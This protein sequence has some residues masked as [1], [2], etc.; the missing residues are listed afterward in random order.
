VVLPGVDGVNGA[1]VV[2]GKLREALARPFHVDEVGLDVEASVG[3][4]V[5]GEHG[6]DAM[7]LLQRVDVAMYVAKER[8]LGVFVYD[9]KFDGHSLERL[10]LLGQLRQGLQSSEL[11]L[12]YQPKVSLSTGEADGVEALVR[13]LHPER[14]LILPDQF[15]PLAEHTGL[16]GPLTL[17]VL[18]MALDQVRAWTDAGFPIPVSVNLSARNL[19]D[20]HFPDQV[21]ALL[22][23]H[24]VPSW[25]LNLEVTE[26]AIMTDPIRAE[27]LLVRLQGLGATIS[28]D[29]FGV[30]YTSLAHLQRLP[31]NEIKIDRS[32]VT[33]MDSDPG[34][35]LIVQ[36]VIDIGHNLGL[37]AI[38]EGV[39][40]QQ[41]RAT[42]GDLG[43]DTAQGYHFSRPLPADDLLAWY[44]HHAAEVCLVATPVLRQPVMR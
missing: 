38:A 5:S 24:G 30:G 19:L 1:V 14:G 22:I 13:W 25:M 9:S 16:I 15:I 11:L 31:V 40:S 4:V 10:K 27:R 35:A 32:F 33:R 6:E 23:K 44:V 41:V 39:E 12:Y 36:S 17:S 8:S 26:S 20:E 43:C 3:V 37:L 28:I 34:R 2:A 42:L 18:D 7:T 21:A 29:D